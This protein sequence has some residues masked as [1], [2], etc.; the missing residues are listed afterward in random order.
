M[1]GVADSQGKH[2]GWAQPCRYHLE[3]Q[4]L[5]GHWGWQ[6]GLIFNDSKADVNEFP[7]SSAEGSHFG[8]AL[9]KESLIQVISS[10]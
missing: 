2:L 5:K 9:G 3:S 6:G 4:P 7:H 1:S 10:T 8:F